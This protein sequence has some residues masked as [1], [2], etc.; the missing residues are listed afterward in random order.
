MFFRKSKS[1]ARI[2]VLVI[3]AMLMQAVGPIAPVFAA[4]GGESFRIVDKNIAEGTAYLDWEFTIDP[5]DPVTV[6]SYAGGFTLNE[7]AGAELRAADGTVLGSYHVT[8]AGA[9][10]VTI[11]Q[12]LYAGPADEQ[13][14]VDPAPAE[15]EE[16]IEPEKPAE[17][18]GPVTAEESGPE[19]AEEGAVPESAPNPEAPAESPEGEATGAPATPTEPAAPAEE[20]EPG[21]PA[22]VPAEPET[23]EPAAP[24]APAAPEEPQALGEYAVQTFTGTIVLPGA[25]E[26]PGLVGK[27]MGL[28][29]VAST[30]KD[31][32]NIF[33]FKSL[34]LDGKEI[35]EN[36]VIE[37]NAGTEVGINFTWDTSKCE[38]PKKGD[39]ATTSLPDIF[40]HT[41]WDNKDIEVSDGSD[42]KIVVGQYSAS[43]GELKF[44]FNE[45][46]ESGEVI[47][48]TVG[49]GL[50]FNLE[51]FRTDVVQEIKFSGLEEKTLTIIAQPAKTA[52]DISKRGAPDSTTDPKSITWT[53][54]LANS[55][56]SAISNAALTD[57][58]PEGLILKADSVTVH[59]LT[60]GQDGGL[61]KGGVVS[62]TQDTTSGLKIAFAEI[63]PYK[64][65]RVEYTTT[66]EDY[67]KLS[68]KNEASL[69]YD[70]KNSPASV[71]VT[72]T[73]SNPIE[74]G[75]SYN[76]GTG[77]IDWTIDVNKSGSTIENAEVA[78]ALPD[79]LTLTK[80]SIK[81]KKLTK[82]GDNWIEGESGKSSATFP[83]E[84]DSI[85]PGDVYRIE[86]STDIDYTKIN[87]G[88]YQENN[89]FTNTAELKGGT[90]GTIVFGTA[91]KEVSIDRKP[92]IEKTQIGNITYTK[93]ELTWQLEINEAKHQLS[94]VEI[95]DTLPAGLSIA[96]ENIKAYQVTDGTATVSNILSEDK[97]DISDSDEGTTIV[98][99]KLGN[100]NTEHYRI[101]YTTTVTDLGKPNFPNQAKMTGTGIEGGKWILNPV[102]IVVPSTSYTKAF[103]GIDYNA[104]T[105]SWKLVVDPQREPIKELT[106]TD[107]FPD[108]G[109]ILLPNDKFTVE[110]GGLTLVAG[111]EGD[112]TLAANGGGYN[113]GFILKFAEKYK[114]DDK[115]LNQV[116]TIK[117]KTSYDPEAGI[118]AHTGEN[119]KYI[120][121]AQFTGT[122]KSNIG[123]NVE[124]NAEITVR[125]DSWNTGKKEGQLVSLNSDGTIMKKGEW[126]S[127]AKRA[128]AWQ[129]YI[130]YQ[131]QKLGT[132][133][134]VTDTLDYE[135]VIDQ[136]SI[137]ISVYDVKS[138]GNTTIKNDSELESEKYTVTPNEDKEFTLKFAEGFEVNE[139][140]VIQ[141]LTSVPDISAVNYKNKATVN[142]GGKESSYT[143]TIGY[144]NY[145]KFLKKEKNDPTVTNVYT[146]DELDWEV[147]I[148]ESLS[149]I[150]EA[151]I[152][153]T[154]SAGLAYVNG[155]LKVYKL[156]GT[157]EEL[158]TTGYTL[159]P[160][161]L[162]DG[163]A[164][165]TIKYTK[166]VD[167]TFVVK[168]KTVVTATNANNL[169]NKVTFTGTEISVTPLETQ[170]L[171]AKQFSY[172]GGQLDPKKGAIRITKK[173]VEENKVITNN[174][175]KFTLWYKLNELW[176]QFGGDNQE[177]TTDKGVL[178]IGGLPLREYELREA[179]PPIGYQG[180]PEP[181]KILVD[182][183]YNSN[184]ANIITE[185]V[186]NTK[187]KI[188]VT[189]TKVWEN[190]PDKKPTI[191]L[192]LYR[193]I[194]A[195][196]ATEAPGAEIKKLANGTTTA[197]WSGM[198]K[199]NIEGKDYTYL[200]QEVDADGN[201]YKPGDPGDYNKQETGLTVTN[202]YIYVS[203]KTEITGT[204][205]W[206][207]GPEVKPDIQLQLYQNNQPLDEPVTLTNGTTTYTWKDLD[208]T[209]PYK[210]DYQYRI[211]EVKT[212][213][214]YGK[215]ISLDGLTITNTY[216]SPQTAITG[217]KIWEGGPSIRPAIQLQLYRNG[218]AFGEPVELADS[219]LSH[220]WNGL[221]TG[222][223]YTVD[224]V[225]VP[226]GYTKTIAPDGLT[227]TNTYSVVKEYAIDLNANPP[228]IVGDG[229]SETVLTARITDE[230]GDPVAGVEIVFEAPVGTF[231]GDPQNPQEGQRT[232]VTDENGEV[233]LLY[234]SEKIEGIESQVIPV[235]ATVTD[236]EKGIYA[237]DTIKIT[238]EPSAITG[239]VTDNLTGQ[240]IPG[241]KIVVTKDFDGDGIIDFRGECITGPDGKYKI[242][243]PKGD[244]V[245]D[246]EIT[247]LILIN[248]EPVDVSFK[249]KAEAGEV[250]AAQGDEEFPA[251]ETFTGVIITRDKDG[252]E[253]IAGRGTDEKIV[254]RQVTAEGTG[255]KEAEV[256][257]KTGVFTIEELA[258]GQTYE[259]VM[260]M[261]VEGQELI[262]GKIVV[263]LNTDGQISIH[264]ELIDPYG[265]ITDSETGKILKDV[266]VELFY[267]DTPRNKAKGRTPHT[268]VI[269]P[270]LPGFA[271]NEN[272][273]PQ[274]STSTTV[275]NDH[276][277][278]KD[279]GN[280]AWMV[281]PE[282]D[283]YI[284]G[285]KTGYN[286]YTSPTISVDF[287]VVKY[288]FAM[289]PLDSGGDGDSDS[290]DDSDSGSGG[291]DITPTPTD[292][293]ENTKPAVPGPTPTTPGTGTPEISE[294]PI[295]TQKPV[296]TQHP[297]N[298]QTSTDPSD[299]QEAGTPAAGGNQGT[300]ETPVDGKG[301]LPKTGENG[302]SGYYMLGMLFIA[303]GLYLGRR[304]TI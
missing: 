27:I 96:K 104:K 105:I 71:T 222:Y 129:V 90:A 63:V 53:I 132:G 48:G 139:R 202:T 225:K 301:T 81:I 82:S 29:R 184:E 291:G 172:V 296:E 35:A 121:K 11:D 288:D 275:F 235:L 152:V 219:K 186:L 118:E 199:T 8:T 79:G 274:L 38:E 125:T 75:G 165:L 83:I 61:Y 277:S 119:E 263:Q 163:P 211:D 50:K 14:K 264:E 87:D 67:K 218:A 278:V 304:R 205:V 140:Y 86:F 37:I 101:Q 59:A 287:D 201:D 252:R 76:K 234:S 259:F 298:L 244:T 100:I 194:G 31:L 40:A 62:A 245:Y 41:T 78:E 185:E 111:E 251:Q 74:K 36:Q 4:T 110:L 34:T 191:W 241:A 17:P 271:P 284:K 22:A 89:K 166:D 133:I 239:V 289:K 95:V 51:K 150:K 85:G 175:A 58:I 215:S 231:L 198:D 143:A 209:D 65:Y 2:A 210:V 116:I 260:T 188:D 1:K 16:S 293:G 9:L 162:P 181:L 302:N 149:V 206:Q 10:T 193:Q 32:K 160:P 269:L 24:Q 134:S 3:L 254:L 212:P 238:F 136:G 56:G 171:T 73:R 57:E 173:D 114:D 47:N 141:F 148:N 161:T 92:I 169:N 45:K 229:K 52:S 180:L 204:K 6:Y 197:V 108:K 213:P 102:T 123:I 164:V 243:I 126:V 7:A 174:E 299:R 214:N 46:I 223:I 135:G 168:Y 295:D 280:Y 203:A 130:N 127:G 91:T 21:E 261:E 257:P 69:A 248:G 294:K 228:I 273:N 292:P 137:K 230:K 187:L 80:D 113:Q 207:G 297:A 138:D 158:Q 5:D 106:I 151:K 131:K 227:I 224:E 68:F 237:T 253:R 285:T 249:Q 208:K 265:T 25:V 98:T 266:D 283:Y 33:T 217:S 157:Q 167:A 170:K 220:I 262:M 13:G 18:E 256:D 216:H 290:S 236:P 42:G 146:G 190:A 153:D 54:D 39:W 55:G 267:A 120:N 64:G 200:V 276:P 156:V 147:K 246:V 26:T 178:T 23:M 117:Y 183:K 268:K 144:N 44:V 93:K 300:D 286:T 19:T 195:D 112:Y 179:T 97:I 66:I 232:G 233:R 30:G 72:F 272:E 247:K 15:P 154:I 177:F 28:L 128:I 196:G 12:E 226:V 88:N 77:K 70:E 250:N 107:T 103:D 20:T 182:K 124:K 142:V 109:L 49:F 155:S 270:I 279:H 84:L 189:A 281:F 242:P 192:K 60:V 282:T 94:N 303:L 99:M 255:G 43:G 240:T 258:K 122:T 221:A 115:A 159:E 176:Q 145:N